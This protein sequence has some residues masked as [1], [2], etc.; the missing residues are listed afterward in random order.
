M[1]RFLALGLLLFPLLA[2]AF[3]P[4]VVRDIR[5]EGIQRVEAG[6]VFSYL[7]IKVGERV[8]DESAA[9]AVRALFATGFFKDVRLEVDRDVLIVVIEERPAISSIEFSGMKE[10]DKDVILKAFKEVGLAESRIFDRSILDRAEQELKRQYLNRGKYGAAISTTVTPLERNRVGVS[11]SI[12]EGD[13]AKILSINVIG[14]QAFREKELI[15]QFKLTT[16]GWLTWYTKNDQYSKQKLSADLES[17][18]SFYS[19]RGYLDFNVESTQV[20]ISPDKK[21]IYI[22]VGIVEG[23]KYTISAVKVGGQMLLPEAE[24]LKLITVKPGD[25]FSR[26]ALNDSVKKITDRLG[27]DGYA[28]ANVNPVPETDKDKRQV[29]FNFLI[30]PGRRV[31]VR[32]INVAGNTRTRDEVIRR[33][34]R[35]LEGA[36]YDTEKLQQSKQRLERTGYFSEVDV[37]TPPVPGTTD[38][39]D[40]TIK[41]KEKPTGNFLL[42]A[43]FSSAEKVTVSTSI[44]QDN[45][46]GSGKSLSAA[47]N[48]SKVAQTYSLSSTDP[49][50]T[51]DGV[52]R[53]FDVYTRMADA[54]K[55]GLGD[56]RTRSTGGGV[57]FGYPLTAVNRLNIGLSV[58]ATQLQLGDVSLGNVPTRYIDYVN[59]F[60][61][62]TT[63]LIGTAG[64]THDDRDSLLWPTKG[65]RRSISVEATAPPGKLRYYKVSAQEQIFITFARDY[66]IMLNGEVGVGNGYSGKPLPFFRNFY[67][68]GMGSVR[69][70]QPSGLGPQ[71]AT[72]AILGGTKKIIGNAEF[73]FPLPGSGRERQFR[74]S[75]FIDGGQVFADGQKV[76][77]SDIRYTAGMSALW[78]SPLGPM[79][80]SLGKPLNDK[81]G[82][83]LQKFQF[84]FGQTF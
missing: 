54:A 56:Y 29:A 2:H 3:D 7:P 84:A 48:S 50:Y 33:E 64:W 52:A 73:F 27:G 53:G 58:E 77:V 41:V 11:F 55:L 63:S 20:S 51:V 49:Y 10:F 22:T 26:E 71:D 16:P 8:T 13:A 67:A 30:D 68:G 17:L 36:Y 43:G 75:A 47:I 19:N 62:N 18:R 34:L 80:I 24:V 65:E 66:T 60:G 21:G 69:G 59:T 76:S 83:K 4:F 70:Y 57:R 39:V 81:P 25:T 38:Q 37:E 1:H 82:D 23:E 12:T 31:Y 79:R 61:A 40:A 72:G 15:E 74:I 78:S 35:Q 32:R 46:F 14:N 9:A 6:T 44:S 45:I 28:F 5:V 42:G